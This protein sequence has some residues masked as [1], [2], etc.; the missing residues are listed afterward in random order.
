[1][2]KEQKTRSGDG[3]DR[4][5]E[6]TFSLQWEVLREEHLGQ[7]IAWYVYRIKSR[8]MWQEHSK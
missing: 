3:G 2:D 5:S 7:E 8:P 4:F 1:M 6:V